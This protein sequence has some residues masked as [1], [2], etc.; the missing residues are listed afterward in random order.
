MTFVSTVML[1]MSFGGDI[2]PDQVECE[3]CGAPR[4]SSFGPCEKCHRLPSAKSVDTMARE[5]VDAGYA[6]SMGE[7]RRYASAGLTKTE[8]ERRRKRNGNKNASL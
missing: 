4:E 2:M 1:P 8:I 7:A 3:W 6:V 5:I